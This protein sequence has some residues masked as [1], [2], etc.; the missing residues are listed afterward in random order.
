M[1]KV[2]GVPPDALADFPV[3]PGAFAAGLVK[4]LILLGEEEAFRVLENAELEIGVNDFDNWNGGTYGWGLRARM[5][6]ES[7][8]AFAPAEKARTEKAILEAAQRL[9]VEHENHGISS[10]LLVPRLDGT[11]SPSGTYDAKTGY[12]SREAFFEARELELVRPIGHGGFSEVHLVRRRLT[13]THLAAKF[14]DPH[15]L[16]VDTP[17]RVQKARSRLLREGALLE[18][19]RHPGVVGLVDCALIRGDPV[20]LLEFVDGEP[21][22]SVRERRGRLPII[23]A[24]PMMI[25]VLDALAACHDQGVIHRDVS[26]KNVVVHP[27][28]KAVLIDFGLGAGEELRAD[29]RLTTQPLGTPGYRAPEL[30]HDPLQAKPTVDVYSAAAVTVF[31]LTG[32]PPQVGVPPQLSEVP[33]LVADGLR[34]AL[35]P[36]PSRRLTS[37]RELRDIFH[38][39][40]SPGRPVARRQSTLNDTDLREFLE[41]SAS[42]DLE[43]PVAELY[44]EFASAVS[45]VPPPEH[46][47]AAL[48]LL[49]AAARRQLDL[50][51]K[52][53]PSTDRCDAESLRLAYGRLIAVRSGKL[54]TPSEVDVRRAFS[55]AVANGWLSEE[56]YDSWHPGMASGSGWRQCYYP[57]V[58]GRRWLAAHLNFELP[59]LE[60]AE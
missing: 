45:S 28:G 54:V 31:M 5:S 58:I 57:T 39:A 36:N 48:A 25:Q 37:A 59:E 40:I 8:S 24:L 11:T 3:D 53:K 41:L 43:G 13:N 29:S 44:R 20:L 26:P 18:S 14:F 22:S 21:M 16:I 42:S 1:P 10:V 52:A 19:I 49:V 32:R 15:P 35:E 23:D 27:S 51:W 47:D 7:F 50:V 6:M 17:E 30:D 55:G 38:E 4:H 12:P 56:E 2:T 46:E 9:F 60:H 34:R 33:L